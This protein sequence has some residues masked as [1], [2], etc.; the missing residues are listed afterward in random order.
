[1][2]RLLIIMVTATTSIV[3]IALLGPM[4]ALIQRFATE[5]ALAAASLEVQAVETVVAFQDRADLVLSLRA[6]NDYEPRIRT[7]VLFPDGDAIGPDKEV[8]DSVLRAQAS[9]RAVSANTGDGV[10]ILVP[11]AVAGENE[12]LDTATVPGEFA[13]I[14]VAVTEA[15]INQQVFIAWGIIAGLGIGLL[16]LAALVASR[17]A[18]NLTRPVNELAGVAGRL[19]GGD[20][21]ARVHPSGPPEIQEVGHALNQLAGR[22]SELLA[23]ERESVADVSHRLR[24]PLAALRLEAGEL[25]DLEER[26]RTVAAVDGL[27]RALDDVIRQARRPIREGIRAACDARRVV[28]ERTTFWSALAEDQN[29]RVRTVLPDHPLLVKVADDDLAA[30]VDA[31]LE[32]VLSHTPEGSDFDVILVEHAE[33]GAVLVIEDRGPGLPAGVGLLERGASGKGSTGLGLDIARSTAEASGGSLR[34][35]HSLYGGTS[36]RLELGAATRGAHAASPR[37]IDV[38]TNPSSFVAGPSVSRRRS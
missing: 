13:V 9:G 15:R 20:L 38:P 32:N 27:S 34:I 19:G 26:Q 1:M 18:R 29:R 14:R 24:T 28:A 37:L 10:E 12:T 3:V 11:V 36:V 33:S 22:I 16:G 23:A 4:A 21:H 7:T 2:R 5:D 8:T 17:L 30:A 31:I 25:R 35:A 6:L